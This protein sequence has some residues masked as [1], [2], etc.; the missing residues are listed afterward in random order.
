MVIIL[1]TF[2]FTS[3]EAVLKKFSSQSEKFPW[4]C[5][6]LPDSGASFVNYVITASLV[7][8][9]LELIRLPDLIIYAFRICYSRSRAETGYIRNIVVNEFRFGEEY[10]RMM[11]IFCMTVIY[12]MLC[13]IITPIGLFYFIMKHLTDRHNLMY[14]YRPSKIS[15]KV[16]SSAINFVVLCT[17][18]L[19]FL[20]MTF[21]VIRSGSWNDLT[22]RSKFAIGIFLLSV[23]I[24]SAQLWSDT[25]QKLSPIEYLECTIIK[26]DDVEKEHKK[27]DIYL[28]EMLMSPEEK[29]RYREYREYYHSKPA[30]TTSYYGTFG[31][32]LNQYLLAPKKIT[33]SF[34][35]K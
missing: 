19:Q 31:S 1:P 23:N 6:F 10:A 17:V 15:K 24:Y 34:L 30:H 16:H 18:M 12:S 8:C 27:N 35:H 26:E 9:G 4:E 7:G 21:N 28:P 11:L 29:A 2:G 32:K 5:I 25:C 13:P 3:I 20:M 14:A 22:L 33:S